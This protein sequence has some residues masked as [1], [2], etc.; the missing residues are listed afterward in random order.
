MNGVKLDVFLRSKA[1]YTRHLNIGWE[2]KF[3]GPPLGSDK[4]NQIIIMHVNDDYITL[5]MAVVKMR[6][7]ITRH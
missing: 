7:K 4:H 5:Q 2:Q 6:G 1:F 3:L